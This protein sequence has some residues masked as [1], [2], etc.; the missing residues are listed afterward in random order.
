MNCVR[1]TI[2]LFAALACFSCRS[3]RTVSYEIEKEHVASE[4][5]IVQISDFHSNDFGAD[6]SKLIKKIKNAAP[7][8]I[9]IT[10]DLYDRRMGEEK[11]FG[12]VELLL[13]G[14]QD[15]C[16]IFFVTGNHDFVNLQFAEKYALLETYG[17]RILHDEVVCFPHDDGVVVIA[18][19]HDPYF[20]LGDS[21]A[22]I[23]R[24]QKEKYRE[25][26][27]A[28]AHKTREAVAAYEADECMI[29][30]HASLENNATLSFAD[31]GEIYAAA[32][33]GD[34]SST[35]RRQRV[36]FTV[37][38]A[39]RPE[40]V[41]DYEQYDFDIILS[42]HTH[43]GQWRFPPFINGVY[44]PGQGTFPKYAGGKYMLKNESATIMIV[45]RGLSYQQ[46]K[47]ARIFNSPE[48]VL[49]RVIKMHEKKKR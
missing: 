8:I 36:L 44:A 37:L 24:D 40:Y 43:G 26:L 49:V 19:I 11:Y 7:D 15:I 14:I 42:G 28:L 32:Q 22:H 38:L 31:S 25:R 47:V 46:P 3:I 2:V 12:N 20:D 17:V 35:Q 23:M 29:E 5:R 27:A 34:G 16:P 1:R 6:E 4:L 13:S 41:D 39:H 33:L 10:G 21:V 30:T 9:V 18:G 48:L 45:C